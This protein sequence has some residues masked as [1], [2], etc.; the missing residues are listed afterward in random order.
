[1]TATRA[2]QVGGSLALVVAVLLGVGPANPS[3]PP[4]GSGLAGGPPDRTVTVHG[5]T[6]SFGALET[7]L[8]SG[9]PAAIRPVPGWG[10]PT[11]R[12]PG[13]TA[14][15]A[16]G[17]VFLAGRDQH[18][19]TGAPTGR[20]LAIGAYQPDSGG[21]T[22]IEIP[23][24][25]GRAV[26]PPVTGLAPLAGGEAVAFT[27]DT[28]YP[29]SDPERDGT[30]PVLGILTNRDG[31]WQ[32]ATGD[33]WANQWT[34]GELRASAPVRS[35]R[36]CPERP[37]GGGASDCRGLGELVSLPYSGDLIVVQAGLPGWYNGALLALR[38]TG[39]DP[40]GRYAVTVTG[41]YLYPNVRDPETGEFLDLELRALQADPT[42]GPDGER[43]VVGLRDLGD[44]ELARPMVIQEFQY[45]PASGAITP[46]SAPTIPGDRGE[47]GSFYGF[48]TASY[49]RDGNLWAARHRRLSAGKLAIYLGG[50]GCRYDPAR[51]PERYRSTAGDRTVWGQACRPDYD[52]LQAQELSTVV[53]LV[54]HPAGP[55]MVAVSLTGAVLAVRPAGRGEA[56]RFQVGNLVDTGLRLLPAAT[57]AAV[58]HVAAGLDRHGRLWLPARQQLPVGTAPAPTDHWLYA[59]RVADLFDPA[60]VPLPEIPGQVATVQAGHTSSTGT[61]PRPG[62]WATTELASEAY[63]RAC[64]QGSTSLGCSYD[65]LP[66]DGFLLGHDSGFGHL[67]GEVSYR[68][69]VPAAGRY[70]VSYRVLT[71]EQTTGA[72]IVLSAGSRRY[73][74]PVDTGGRWLT[75]PVA[76]PVALPAGVQTIRLSPPEDRGGWYLSWFTLQLA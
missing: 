26:A 44:R 9:Q 5:R 59:V 36:A 14:L 46:V 72:E 51:E 75:V 50:L 20:T 33:G 62:A 58:I 48:A 31:V 23:P 6:G 71:F 70:R 74:T 61:R 40:A 13:A 43:F 67:A 49:D 11:G 57:G 3:P 76:E 64:G 15:A 30:W 65:G 63:L 1:M 27:T 39:P 29:D 32:V 21:Y 42:G 66:G 10:L 16:D 41:F 56:M 37:G 73:R 68:V 54:R 18:D 60:P 12:Q 34:G 55:E 8:P 2:R 45:D 28:S 22:T 25:A 69:D 53:S 24:S 4:A 47:D 19:G 17:T 35:E 38:L 52:L 7:R